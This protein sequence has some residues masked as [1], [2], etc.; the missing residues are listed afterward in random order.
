MGK[1][2]NKNKVKSIS[3]EMVIIVALISF[4]AGYAIHSLVSIAD[5]EYSTHTS[6]PVSV[7][8]PP[9]TQVVMDWEKQLMDK[10]AANPGDVE[11]WIKLGN[12]Y[13]DA[14]SYEK[15]IHAYNRALAINPDNAD[16]VTDL[17][18]M[19]RRNGQAFDALKAFEE[20]EKI[21]PAH[22]TSNFNKGIVLYH[23]LGKKGEA[24]EVWRDLSINYP[25]YRMPD[26][27]LLSEFLSSID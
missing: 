12:R 15:A 10:V 11:A 26:G 24:I 9:S 4:I 25:L 6:P 7:S 23:D 17:G 20:A 13:F 18:V 21:N 1:H 16:V 27:Q 5:K 3:K 8:Q 19:Y 2:Q 22:K 14:S